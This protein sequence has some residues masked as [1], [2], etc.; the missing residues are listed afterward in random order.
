MPRKGV[1]KGTKFNG[2]HS[3]YNRVAEEIILAIKKHPEVKKIVLGPIK[4][5]GP[6]HRRVSM[7]EDKGQV[8]IYCR[9]S[10]SVQI[11]WAIGASLSVLEALIPE[12]LRGTS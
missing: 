12:S 11:L 10:G 1:L 8:R 7:R 4:N 5:I 6:G 9:D 3:T 2:R